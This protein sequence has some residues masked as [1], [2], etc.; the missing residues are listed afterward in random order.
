MMIF[1]DSDISIISSSASEIFFGSLDNIDIVNVSLDIRAYDWEVN[2]KTGRT[3][4]LQAMEVT[5]NI[6]R[7]AAKYAESHKKQNNEDLPF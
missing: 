2:G 6:D 4:Y 7:F 5:Q 3:A 1:S